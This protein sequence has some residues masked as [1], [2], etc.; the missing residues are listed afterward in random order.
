MDAI[1]SGGMDEALVDL[2][3]HD[4]RALYSLLFPPDRRPEAAET[5]LIRR[6]KLDQQHI[7]LADLRVLRGDPDQAAGY[8]VAAPG[9]HDVPRDG[10]DIADLQMKVIIPI[11]VIPAEIQRRGAHEDFHIFKV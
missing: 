6:R 7:S 1:I 8:E 10:P 11:F 9:G 3:D 2:R 5:I 4:F